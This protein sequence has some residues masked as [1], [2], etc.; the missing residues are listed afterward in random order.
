MS[1]PRRP[2]TWVEVTPLFAFEPAIRKIIY[3]TDVIDKN[4]VTGPVTDSN[5]T[6]FD[7]YQFFDGPT[8]LATLAVNDDVDVPMVVA[9]PVAGCRAPSRRVVKTISVNAS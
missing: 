6:T 2:T 7:I 9:R 8:L 4:Q 5:G 3:T 1:S